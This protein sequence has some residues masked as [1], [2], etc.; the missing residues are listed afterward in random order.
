MRRRSVR[1]RRSPNVACHWE[2]SQFVLEEFVSRSR[3]RVSHLA[4]SILGLA[5]LVYLPVHLAL[6]RLFG[7]QFSLSSRRR[8]TLRSGA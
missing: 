6:A 1:F 8:E 7:E 3:I 4:V 5:V 2:G